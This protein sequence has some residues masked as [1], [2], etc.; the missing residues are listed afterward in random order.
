MPADPATLDDL[1]QCIARLERR[2]ALAGPSADALAGSNTQAGARLTFGLA[3]IDEALPGG[4]LDAAGMHEILDGDGATGTGGAATGFAAA[5]AG[6]R[7]RDSGRPIVW[8]APRHDAHESLYLHG[9]A[10]YGL[11][12]DALLVVRIPGRG[13]SA[14]TQTLWALEEC[15]RARSI[16]LVCAALDTLDLT[17]S[18]RLQLAAAAGGTTGLLLR[19]GVTGAA[20]ALPPTASLTRWRIASAPSAPC[21]AGDPCIPRWRVELLRARNGRPHQWLLEWHHDPDRLDD[22]NA[23]HRNP[24]RRNDSN[25]RDESRRI[26]IAQPAHSGPVRAGSLA[27][28]RSPAGFA[29]VA[30]LCDRPDLPAQHPV[31]AARHRD[32]A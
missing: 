20:P 16:G 7:Q 5:L 1:R 6:R 15:L 19:G 2:S 29:L 12:A 26:A 9:L 28:D 11:A 31:S 25:Q 27:G 22:R 30:P 3:A 21:L 18:R 4:G 14:A 8:I 17:A 32:A 10:T 24:D 23:D 13:R